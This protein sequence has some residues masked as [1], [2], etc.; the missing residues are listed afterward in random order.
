MRFIIPLL[1][2]IIPTLVYAQQYEYAASEA[3]PFGRPHPDAPKQFLDYEPLIGECDCTST[4]RNPDQTWG[5]PEEMVWRFSYIMNGTAVQ[6]QT[7]KANGG[8]SGSIRQYIAD[9]STWYVHYYSNV[10]PSTKLS[11]WEGGMRGD[12]IVLYKEQK[13]PTGVDG[14]YRITF[15]DISQDG[16]NWIGE[17]V[18]PGETITFPTW[19]IR[20]RKRK[21]N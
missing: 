14:F 10:A 3:Y 18:D 9:S 15:N 5:E 4:R 11:A 6:D 12:S 8:H 16:F 19:K 1:F 20:C 2:L 13:T 17:W 21:E 7:L